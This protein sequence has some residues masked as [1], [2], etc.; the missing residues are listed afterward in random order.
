MLGKKLVPAPV[1]LVECSE[2]P[3]ELLE[4]AWR[5]FMTDQKLSWLLLTDL[6]VYVPETW[7]MVV[8]SGC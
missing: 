4:I 3:A 5:A 2:L 8:A 6:L 1:S 7:L